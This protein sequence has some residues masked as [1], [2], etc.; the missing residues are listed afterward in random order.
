[1][2]AL[3]LIIV[4]YRH[5]RKGIRRTTEV[6]ELITSDDK[7]RLNIIYRWNPQI[8]KIE[9]INEVYRVYDEISMYS[10]MTKK[11]IETDLGNKVIILDWMMKHKIKTVDSVGKILAEYYRDEKKVISTAVAN[12]SPRDILGDKIYEE[13]IKK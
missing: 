2:S 10:G 4:Q 12:Q 11:E 5:R 3:H 8:D 1:M 9:K 7:C 13:L 6:A